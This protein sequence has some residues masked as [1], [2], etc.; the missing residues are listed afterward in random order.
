[1][2][3]RIRKGK[4]LYYPGEIVDLPDEIARE[5][6]AEGIASEYR[7]PSCGGLLGENCAWYY[8]NDCGYKEWK[9]KG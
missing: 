8:C 7:C 6:V 9:D 2:L 3:V 4:D 1:M 5:F